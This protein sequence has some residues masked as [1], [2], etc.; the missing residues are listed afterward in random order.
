MLFNL[1]LMLQR[2]RRYDES[3]EVLRH[4]VTMRHSTDLYGSFRVWTAFEEAI[5]G[6]KEAAQQQLATLP[7]EIITDVR[8]PLHAMTEL[9]LDVHFG[10]GDRKKLL[11]SI[12]DRLTQVFAGWHPCKAEPYTKYGYLRFID[13]VSHHLHATHLWVWGQWYYRG[14]SWLLVPGLMLLIPLAVAVPPIGIFLLAT[15]IYRARN[16]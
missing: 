1:I 9:L 10:R 4:A 14:V 7:P 11:R 15:L 3:L 13:I 2:A 6:N 16:R 5:R 8:R 12:K